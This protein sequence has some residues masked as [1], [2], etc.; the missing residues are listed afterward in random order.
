[1]AE[2]PGLLAV[3]RQNRL[4]AHVAGRPDVGQTAVEVSNGRRGTHQVAKTGSR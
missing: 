4:A 1:M 3:G 2:M